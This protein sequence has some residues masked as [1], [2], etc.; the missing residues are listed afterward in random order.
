MSK[1][2]TVA[3][4]MLSD[5]GV[6]IELSSP[7]WLDWVNKHASFRYEPITDVTGFTARAEKSGYWYG[8]RKVS[9]KLH[10]RYIGKPEE[11]TVE[12]L[13][14]IAQLLL[15]PAQRREVCRTEDS[16]RRASRPEEVT[17]EI[18][19]TATS[20]TSATNDDIARLWEALGE[21]R[22]SVAALGK[23]KAR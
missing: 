12:R 19:A 5:D 14:E 15:K 23:L 21:L 13:E 20:T 10:K 4:G 17:Q 22:S 1:I 9:G 8:Y 18:S 2:P 7:Q 6:I 16:V 3:Q 11:L